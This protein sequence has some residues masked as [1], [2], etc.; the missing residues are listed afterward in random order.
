ASSSILPSDNID[1]Y[2]DGPL[3]TGTT[4][5]VESGFADGVTFPWPGAKNTNH[6]FSQQDFFNVS[7]TGNQILTPPGFSA[8]LQQAGTS[9]DTYNAYTF[10]RLI[11]QLG[12]D[13]AGDQGKLNVN[14]KN[15]DNRGTV[16][17]GAET[18]MVGWTALDFF[19]NAAAAMFKQ[20]DLRDMNGNLVTVTN[21]PIYAD[22]AL[23]PNIPTNQSYYTP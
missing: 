17:L 8:R 1:Q 23:Y 7:K 13:S 19:T 22:P 4:N 16:L 14:Y 18:N 3:M 21:I 20:M 11:S 10:Y 5:I 6:Y 15:T 2:S 12:T 9:N